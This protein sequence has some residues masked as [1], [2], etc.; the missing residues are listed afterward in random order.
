M[1]EK[2]TYR[3]EIKSKRTGKKIQHFANNED[4]GYYCSPLSAY[5]LTDERMKDIALGIVYGLMQYKQ[6]YVEVYKLNE[7]GTYTLI[8]TQH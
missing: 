5:Q 8:R 7:Q 1:N 2:P 4:H 3:I 6:I